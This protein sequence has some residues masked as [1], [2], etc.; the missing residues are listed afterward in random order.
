MKSDQKAQAKA[1]KQISKLLRKVMKY[2]LTVTKLKQQMNHG[3]Y[4]KIKP[5]LPKGGWSASDNLNMSGKFTPSSE[6]VMP[7][8][9]LK[10]KFYEAGANAGTNISKVFDDINKHVTDANVKEAFKNTIED[11]LEQRT[12][13]MRKAAIEANNIK[14]EDWP[15]IGVNA[16]QAGERLRKVLENMAED[17]PNAAE[18]KEQQPKPPTMTRPEMVL[19][20]KLELNHTYLAVNKRAPMH[21]VHGEFT[22]VTAEQGAIEF[23]WF[24]SSKYVNTEDFYFFEYFAPKVVTP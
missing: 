22:A 21:Q 20:D 9:G 19:V 4:G 3:A 8:D 16:Q 1:F 2:Q 24:E 5:E 15:N 17:K 10:K 12:E 13:E 7:S 11:Q 14:S 23:T 18:H 6:P